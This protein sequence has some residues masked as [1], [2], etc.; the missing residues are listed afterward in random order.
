MGLRSKLA[1]QSAIMFAARIFG[2][3]VVFLTQAAIGRFWGAERLGEYLLL[4]AAINLVGVFLPLGF[5]TIGTYFAA[6]YRAKGQGRALWGFLARAYFH[7]AVVGALVFALG[8]P[9]VGLLGEP[10]AIVQAHWLPVGLMA[11]SAALVMVS[12]AALIGL[13]RPMAGYFADS[14]FRPMVVVFAFLIALLLLGAPDA[15]FGGFVWFVA[16][17]YFAVAVAQFA[18]MIMVVRQIPTEMP[19]PVGEQRRWWRFA[20]P[21]MVIVLATDFFFDL[22]LILLAGHLSRE[23]LAIFGVCT[24]IFSLVSFAVVAVYSVTL[25]DIFEND[26]L[27]DKAGFARRIGDANLVATTIAAILLGGMIVGGPVAL[28]LFGPAFMAGAAPLGVLCLGLIVR[29]ALGPASLVLSIHDRPYAPLPAI[30]LG[31][32]T[33]VVGNIV[34][35]PLWGLTGA[36]V[37][38]LLSMT[39]WSVA[40]WYTAYRLAGV[41]VSLFARL[42]RGNSPDAVP[43]E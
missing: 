28:M 21:W 32:T 38:A 27:G 42:R 5:E 20:L 39:V 7:V 22:D 17:G 30:A 14:V 23:E 18:Y 2:A 34:M 37:A 31:V 43:A 8:Y 4:M 11:L 1:S 16:G 26:A 36:A 29:S 33:L 9:V 10:G 19:V 13:K 41:D 25:P 35:V 12:G 6:E 3:G 24:R 15:E 40:L